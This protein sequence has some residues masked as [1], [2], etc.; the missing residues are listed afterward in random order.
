MTEESTKRKILLAEDDHLR[1]SYL[2]TVLEVQGFT[3]IH[4]H[5]GQEAVRIARETTDLALI[6]MDIK[7]PDKSGIEATRE[8][9]TFNNDIPIIAQTAYALPGNKED[10]MKAG[11]TDYISKPIERK[12]LLKLLEKYI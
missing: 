9:R 7:M 5:T 3:V 4:A 10:I 11:C 8:I 2:K 12:M 1:L 6:L